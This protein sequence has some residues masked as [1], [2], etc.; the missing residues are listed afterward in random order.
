MSVY[1]FGKRWRVY[2]YIDGHGRDIMY[3]GGLR[4]PTFDPQSARQ[5]ET[6]NPT[7]VVGPADVLLDFFL[8]P[9]VSVWTC[10]QRN[11]DGGLRQVLGSTRSISPNA[12]KAPCE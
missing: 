1:Y 6:N 2:G 12:F 4:N 11:E 7:F 5:R 3:D 9:I 8:S 10:V